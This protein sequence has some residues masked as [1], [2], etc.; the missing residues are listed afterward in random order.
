MRKKE[1]IKYQKEVLDAYNSLD[2]DRDKPYLISGQRTYS[3]NDII[4]EIEGLT[5]FGMKTIRSWVNLQN[6]IKNKK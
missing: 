4:K 1:L 5:D 3:I 6:Y 2:R